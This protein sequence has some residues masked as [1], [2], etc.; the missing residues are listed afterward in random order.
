MR[1]RG[2]VL[3]I[4]I[5]VLLLLGFLGTIAGLL[6]WARGA[7]V[8]GPVVLE[9]DLTQPWM[10]HVPGDALA[11]SLL[12]GRGDL[13]RVVDAIDRAAGDDDVA[14]L[15][16]RVGSAPMGL[17]TIQE[18]RDAVGRFGASG[19]RTVAYADTFGEW[20]PG[21]GGYYLASGFD[22]VYLQ[23]SG[24]VGLTGL[25][26]Q[27][28]FLA[29]T[30]EKIGL[31]PQMDRRKEYKSAV[32]TYTE[33]EFTEAQEEALGAVAESQFDQ[34]VTGI[35]AARGLEEPAVRE[36]VDR[37]PYFGS[38]AVAA[39]LVDGLAYRDEV[40][41]RL[42]ESLGEDV[43]FRDVL[44]YARQTLRLPGG[45]TV[46]LIYGVGPVV[47]GESE[48]DF[49]SGTTTLGSDTVAEAFRSAVED[50]SVR[51][52]LFRVDSPGGSYV[53]SDTVWRETVRA[54]D[55]GK[56]VVVSMSNLA[57]SGGYFVAMAADSIVAHPGTVTGSIGVYGGKILSRQLWNKL[58]ITWDQVQTSAN[59]EM[60]SS[61]DAFD[62]YGWQRMQDSL[63]RI[64]D[65][66]VDK[67]ASGRGLDA[68]TVERVARGRIWTGADALEL[69][70]V[71][72]L[73]GYPAALEEIRRLLGL[74]EGVRIRL[75]VFPAPR[76]T[77][78]LIAERLGARLV[79]QPVRAL[80]GR[81]VE[82][83]ATVGEVLRA[84]GVVPARRGTLSMPPLPEEP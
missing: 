74:E 8:G 45:E 56:P 44:A 11:R 13:R 71:D 21:N 69:G 43:A 60:F 4:V 76:S 48:Y 81:W 57:G 23:P 33:T 70:L 78:E 16:A 5:I 25:I 61:L 63:D 19:K 30:F 84:A 51:A 66:F 50:S 55:A 14:A 49:L 67:V 20:G 17:A 1:S 29:G 10:E 73:G 68:Q 59:S 65:D 52:I 6:L 2:K 7:P 35:A 9:I 62:E 18:L 31:E 28:S 12:D 75:K 64:Y 79:P 39:G 38:E 36:L 58:G 54:R 82:A 77:L 32:N 3:L 27:V 41:D 37:G 47:R 40:Y 46:A 24:D 42:R 83:A 80:A 72:R 26:Y 53:G 15:L 22:E 34:L